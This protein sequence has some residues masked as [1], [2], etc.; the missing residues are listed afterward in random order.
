MHFPLFRTFVKKRPKGIIPFLL[1]FVYS[2]SNVNLKKQL[3]YSPDLSYNLT[4]ETA[5]QTWLKSCRKLWEAVL[6]TFL[7]IDSSG[8]R[9]NSGPKSSGKHSNLSRKHQK[10]TEKIRKR[11]HQFFGTR[12]PR[13]RVSPLGPKPPVF[14]AKTGGFVTQFLCLLTILLHSGHG[15]QT[16]LI[17][18]MSSVVSKMSTTISK[19]AASKCGDTANRSPQ[20][21][22]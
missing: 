8:T 5:S 14:I 4:N 20:N 2:N 21:H 13:V 22:N 3:D 15:E 19:M 9:G 10:R 6:T 1:F 7:T 17:T 16:C 11:I 18:R 12:M